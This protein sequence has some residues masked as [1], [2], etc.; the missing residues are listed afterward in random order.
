MKSSKLFVCLGLAALSFSAQ[1][2]NIAQIQT[3]DSILDL[4]KEGSYEV[5]V[6]DARLQDAAVFDLKKVRLEQIDN[7]FTMKYLVPVELTGEKNLMEFKGTMNRGQGNLIYENTT[8]NCNSD[9]VTLT[10][11]VAYQN[12]KFNQTKAE[13]LL[14]RKFEGL[15]LEKRLTIQKDFSTDP[16]GIIK[17][18]LK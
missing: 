2:Q 7:H 14:A 13:K 4:Y 10:C 1:A 11:K 9:E 12:L 18:K 16:V 6:T 15:A 17:V 3:T 5:P 8:M